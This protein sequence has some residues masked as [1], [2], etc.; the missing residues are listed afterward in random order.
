M[1]K[2]SLI[3]QTPIRVWILQSVK[4][5]TANQIC[6]YASCGYLFVG[7]H[8][9]SRKFP[10]RKFSKTLQDNCTMAFKP[11]YI[12]MF[13]FDNITGSWRGMQ[14]PETKLQWKNVENDEL[15]NKILV[16]L[17]FVEQTSS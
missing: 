8:Q 11:Y 15:N 9:T 12:Y 14:R 3:I 10:T 2:V 17:L 5:I 6:V 16:A 13:E 7:H 4:T 1:W